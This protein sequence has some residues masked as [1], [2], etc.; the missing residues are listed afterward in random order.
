MEEAKKAGTSPTSVSIAPAN[1]SPATVTPGSG[2]P[3]VAAP[4]R[5]RQRLPGDSE[6]GSTGPKSRVRRDANELK[7][8]AIRVLSNLAEDGK[9]F[10]LFETP[11][12]K[13]EVVNCWN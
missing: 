4:T 3:Q 5:R 9:F 2:G 7:F 10:L 12:G 8:E 6:K 11:D 13:K 1:P